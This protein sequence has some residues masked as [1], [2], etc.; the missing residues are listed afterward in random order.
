VFLG[1]SV[2]WSLAVAGEAGAQ[3]LLEELTDELRIALAMCGLTAPDQAT[4]DLVDVN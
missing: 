3:F 2:V 1:R 4:R